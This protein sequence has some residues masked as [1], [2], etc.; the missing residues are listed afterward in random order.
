[1][2]SYP[3]S[4]PRQPSKPRE[5]GCKASAVAV[6]RRT[7]RPS[8]PA[9]RAPGMG[10]GGTSPPRLPMARRPAPVSRL[11]GRTKGSKTRGVG[12]PQR[13]RRP[14]RISMPGISTRGAS[15][16]FT[17]TDNSG[18]HTRLETASSAVSS[19]ASS[20]KLRGLG[21]SSMKPNRGTR[22]GIRIRRRRNQGLPGGR[23]QTTPH[24][25]TGLLQT[26]QHQLVLGLD[27]EFAVLG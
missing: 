9:N 25:A 10:P 16:R 2:D 26:G 3:S 4:A 5:S 8:K 7:N 12:R 1:M 11:G 27:E 20:S 24:A 14:E 6:R 23:R 17:C 22:R 21:S 13:P 18:N 19:H 15:P